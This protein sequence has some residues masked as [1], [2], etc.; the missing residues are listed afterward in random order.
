VAAAVAEIRAI[1][2]RELDCPSP[3]TPQAHLLR[4]LALDSYGL[5]VI[6]VG[7]EDRFRVRLGEED[8]GQIET[9]EDLATLVA[10]RMEEGSAP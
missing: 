1:A 10:R 9:V 2:E 6:A 7:L 8:A 3:V 5:M 4:D